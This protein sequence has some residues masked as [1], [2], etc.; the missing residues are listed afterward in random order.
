MYEVVSP[1]GKPSTKEIPRLASAGLD[2]AG[3]K[4]GLVRIPFPNGDVLLETM[5]D[6][7]KKRFKG[8]EFVKLPS[9]KGLA[10][11]DYPDS[12]LTGLV[13]ESGIAAALVA[14]GC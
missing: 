2:L 14:V 7:M 10:W 5:A 13:K 1:A 9:G 12:S 3:K 11:G 6:L 8:L 4:V